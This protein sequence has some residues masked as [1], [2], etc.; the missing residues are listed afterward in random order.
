MRNFFYFLSV[1]L[2]ISVT[3][4]GSGGG[5]DDSGPVA[6]TETFQ[7]RAA[8]ENIITTSSTSPFTMSGT[9]SGISL[10]GS[11]TV[12]ESSLTP[13]TFEGISCFQ[14]V[15]TVTG[16]DIANNQSFPYAFTFTDY[17]D[18]NHNYIGSEGGEYSVV[19]GA[20][21]L[22]QT[23]KVNDTGIM[24]TE[25]TYSSNTKSFLIGT[26]TVSFSLEPD[27]ASTAL[28][29]IITTEKDTSNSLVSTSVV[30]WR[31]TP[32]GNFTRLY[33]TYVGGGDNAKITY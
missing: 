8:Y 1:L 10:T 19:N 20:M 11:G 18:A 29:K 28:L 15:T 24:F 32:T 13:A 27:T 30:A 21:T 9:S 3:G 2:V 5:D 4:C 23:A 14:Q 31:L 25:N 6:S 7:L 16:T 17:Y 26:S 12:V 22:P 33:E